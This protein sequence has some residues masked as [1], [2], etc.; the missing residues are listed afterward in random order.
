MHG[1]PEIPPHMERSY[2]AAG[3]EWLTWN[4]DYATVIRSQPYDSFAQCALQILW[5]ALDDSIAF[6][7][8][9]FCSGMEYV[10]VLNQCDVICYFV[11]IRCSSIKDNNC[12]IIAMCF[13]KILYTFNGAKRICMRGQHIFDKP[14]F[15][16]AHF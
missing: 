4:E 14:A 3:K 15:R 6:Q 16:V 10:T 2:H 9:L 5:I 12:D 8:A 11:Q 13:N 7:Q 1:L